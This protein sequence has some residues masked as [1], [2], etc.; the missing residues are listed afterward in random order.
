MNDIRIPLSL[1]LSPPLSVTDALLSGH[2]QRRRYREDAKGRWWDSRENLQVWS[3]EQVT[4]AETCIEREYYIDQGLTMRYKEEWEGGAEESRKQG[5]CRLLSHGTPEPRSPLR[6]GP[7]IPVLLRVARARKCMKT[8]THSPS[9][10]S[11]KLH[12]LRVLSVP[13]LFPANHKNSPSSPANPLILHSARPLP[14][15]SASLHFLG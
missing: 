8:S 14:Q 2:Y 11:A 9:P 15:F 4:E 12:D 10:T 13:K 1:S 3:V 5:W 7:A 6:A